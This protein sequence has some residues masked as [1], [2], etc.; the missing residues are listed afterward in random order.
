MAMWT[1]PVL[2]ES[3]GGLHLSPHPCKR[4]NENEGKTMTRNVFVRNR[5]GMPL[6]PTTPRKARIL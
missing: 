4:G 1:T 6:M 5:N 2:L 3:G